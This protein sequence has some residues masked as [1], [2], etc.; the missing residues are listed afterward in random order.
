MLL[1][2]AQHPELEAGVR[3]AHQ[4]VHLR[5]QAVDRPC[6]GTTMARASPAR[7]SGAGRKF[8][9][10]CHGISLGFTYGTFHMTCFFS[11]CISN[12]AL[13][14]PFHRRIEQAE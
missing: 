11:N 9:H 5:L 12:F 8:A 14:N 13:A 3:A 10:S 7:G 6:R 1:H 2:I 4:S